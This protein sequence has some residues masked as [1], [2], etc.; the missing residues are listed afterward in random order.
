ML[1]LSFISLIVSFLAAFL[2]MPFWIRKTKSI[3]LL[4]DDMNKKGKQSIPGSGGLIVVLSFI[5]GSLTYVAI[6]TFITQGGNNFLGVFTITTSILLL[7]GIG[8]ID[9]LLGWHHGGLKKYARLILVLFAAVPLMVVNAGDS[10]IHLLGGLDVGILYPLLFI[11]IG[12]VGATTTYNFLAGYNGLEAGQGI[13]ILSALAIVAFFT[14]SEWLAIIAGCMVVS[15]LGF[16]LYNKYPAKIFPGD[17][18]TYPVGGF[19][20]IMAI[21]GNFEAFAIF[22]FIPYILETGLKLRGK[23]GKQSFGEP[24]SDGSLKNRYDK[25]YGLEHVAISILEKIKKSKKAYEWEVVLLIHLFQIVIII[26]GFIIFI[27]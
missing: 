1:D 23:L 12:I 15:L 16:L 8:I 14:G 11:P 24:Q 19:I 13:L 7:A 22:I 3:G 25:H 21:V 26:L 20:A 9:D 2:L 27:I 4:W 5:L 6:Q 18:L 10:V 17:V